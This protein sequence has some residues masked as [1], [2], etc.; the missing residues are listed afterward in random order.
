MVLSIPNPGHRRAST[1]AN[2]VLAT[3]VAA[4]HGGA[5]QLPKL[6]KRSKGA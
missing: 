2:R 4:L 5:S 6:P 3:I 1:V